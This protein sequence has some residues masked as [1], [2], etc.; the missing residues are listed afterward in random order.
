MDTIIA[1][2]IGAVDKKAVVL[3]NVRVGAQDSRTIS[4]SNTATASAASLDVTTTV[5]GS[6]QASGTISELTAGATD[7]KDL[8][9]GIGTQTAGLQ[10]GTVTLDFFSDLG[11]GVTVPALPDQT[12]TVTGAVYREAQAG[13]TLS[14]SILHVG[15]PGTD[16]L[17]VTNTDPADGYSEELIASLTS[18]SGQLSAGSTGATGAIAAG[19]HDSSSLSVRIPTTQS[20]TVS[21]TVT[22]DLISDGGTVDGLGTVDLGQET[23]SLTARFTTMRPRRSRD[24]SPAVATLS[25]HGSD[26]TLNF[27]AVQ[28]GSGPE[29]VAL[30]V[31]NS[32]AGLADALS[33]NFTISNVSG[34]FINTDFAGFSGIGSK[35]AQGGLSVALATGTAGMFS[36]TITLDPTGSDPG[37]SGTLPAETL[38]VEGT[39]EAA[40]AGNATWKAPM[41]GDWSVASDWSDDAVPGS[42]NSTSISAA[43]TYAVTISAAEAA[44]SVMVDAA[45]ATLL[46]HNSLSLGTSLSV[47][48]GTVDLGAGGA[49]G[50]GTSIANA[51]LLEKTGADNASLAENI[52]NTGAIEAAAGALTLSGSL[53]GTGSL[54]VSVGATLDLDRAT[55]STVTTAGTLEVAGGTDSVGGTLVVGSGG[56]LV[57]DG[58]VAVDAGGT[59]TAD[60]VLIVNSGGTLVNLGAITA[61]D[62]AASAVRLTAGGSVFNGNSADSLATISGGAIGVWVASGFATLDNSANINAG[63]AGVF[64]ASTP[65]AR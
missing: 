34:A 44:K 50:G 61:P 32:A 3:P 15:D 54:A 12:V 33:G 10:T 24:L 52:D 51:G 48:A 60:G 20:G 56:R 4:V 6:S 36:E 59:L 37:F 35:S 39:V 26:Y 43:G 62:N 53:T 46:L 41:S 23:V 9:V 1:P 13:I 58:K 2:A 21:G 47:A 55:A 16:T 63:N 14:K 57:D 7:G 45:G 11:N 17:T 19:H 27:G 25:G 30:D 65:P 22:L 8:S 40:T 64:P 28:Q 49:I 5:S 31:R 42:D 38:T 18:A 29:D